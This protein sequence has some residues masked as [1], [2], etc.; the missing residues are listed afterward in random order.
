[1]MAT[2]AVC[3]GSPVSFSTDRLRAFADKIHDL[4]SVRTNSGPKMENFL[5]ACSPA[6]RKLA[7]SACKF[8]LHPSIEK[9]SV[10][11]GLCCDELKVCAGYTKQERRGLKLVWGMKKVKKCTDIPT[12]DFDQ[13]AEVIDALVSS[14]KIERP[15]DVR[16]DVETFFSTCPS[17]HKEVFGESCDKF[18]ANSDKSGNKDTIGYGFCCETLEVCPPPSSSVENGETSPFYTQTWFFAVC[19]GVGLLLIGSIVVVAY[20]FCIRKKGGGGKSGGGG[21]KSSKKS[22]KSK[23]KK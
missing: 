23:S 11:Y 10:T 22:T 19:G 8:V 12:R 16:G 4:T 6:E 21:M 1:M 5:G 18:Y 3:N 15:F 2:T 17:K 7:K 20:F 14:Y 9:N 13:K